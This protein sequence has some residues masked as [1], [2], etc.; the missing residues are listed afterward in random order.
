MPWKA[1]GQQPFGNAKRRRNPTECEALRRC[2]DISLQ[3]R[4]QAARLRNRSANSLRN[5][6]TLGAMTAWQYPA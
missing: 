5:L 4:A 1:G 3:L 6:A 2:V